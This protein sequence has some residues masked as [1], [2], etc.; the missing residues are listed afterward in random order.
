MVHIKLIRL[1]KKLYFD[2]HPILYQFFHAL[3]FILKSFILSIKNKCNFILKDAIRI[4]LI[5]YTLT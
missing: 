1:T 4:D 3:D 5:H 2:A